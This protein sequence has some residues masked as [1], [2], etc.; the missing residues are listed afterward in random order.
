MRSTIEILD[1]AK[2]SNS[3]YWIAQQ[4]GI[5]QSVVT[6]WRT[7]KQIGAESVV[8]LC[9]LAGIPVAKGLAICAFEKLKDPELKKQIEDTVSFKSPRKTLNRAFSFA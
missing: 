9:Q 4:L 2:G 5:K 1:Q 7:R 3:D 8:K 6:T